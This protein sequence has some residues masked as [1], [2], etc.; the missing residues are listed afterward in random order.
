METEQWVVLA[1]ILVPL[2]LLSWKLATLLQSLASTN[3]RTMEHERRDWFQLV[4]RLMEKRNLP[5]DT[6]SDLAAMHARE[7]M[8]RIDTD[9]VTDR[10]AMEKPRKPPPK[11]KPPM[12]STGDDILG[13]MLQ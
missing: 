13:S 2:L 7:R 10:K 4:E 9:G 3:V 5:I 8:N 11:E 1:L 12:V 6:Q